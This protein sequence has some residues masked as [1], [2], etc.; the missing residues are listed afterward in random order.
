MKKGRKGEGRSKLLGQ[1][2]EAARDRRRARRAGEKKG[3]K[4]N[5]KKR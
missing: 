3:R 5:R 2:F 1:R 4:L